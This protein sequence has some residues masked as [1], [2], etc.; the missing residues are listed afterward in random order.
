MGVRAVE[1]RRDGAGGRRAGA[2]GAAGRAARWPAVAASAALV[3]L[4]CAPDARAGEAGTHLIA[5]VNLG[6]GIA[7]ET[8]LGP[9]F[10]YG[11]LVGIGG[12][13][14]DFPLRFYFVT[15]AD[16]VSFSGDGT[17]PNTGTS[18]DA[19]R[20]YV[21]IF[22][23]LRLLLP[24]YDQIRAYVDILGAA[25]Y[26]DGSIHRV[27]GPAIGKQDW[28]ADSSGRSGCSTAGTS[29]PRP[30]SAPRCCSAARRPRC[31]TPTP[32]WARAGASASPC[33]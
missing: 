31:W 9:D 5:E 25:A 18:F 14:R 19:A 15:G 6:L 27:D 12:K 16:S 33:W 22:G 24:I 30:A 3:V 13:F 8:Y 20:T 7:P 32:A 28:Y 2:G 11:G 23:G 1:I 4:A 29:T 10:A 21:D 17:N 26:I